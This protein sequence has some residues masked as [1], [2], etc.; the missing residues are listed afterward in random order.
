MLD[1]GF[2]VAVGVVVGFFAFVFIFL[3]F[4]REFGL[5]SVQSL[6]DVGGQGSVDDLDA[7]VSAQHQQPDRTDRPQQ[8]GA[9]LDHKRDP[10]P[11]HILAKQRIEAPHG[12]REDEQIRHDQP[13]DQRAEDHPEPVAELK[14]LLHH[15]FDRPERVGAHQARGDEQQAPELHLGLVH[16]RVQRAVARAEHIAH[17][18]LAAPAPVD[19]LRRALDVGTADGAP[20]RALALPRHRGRPRRRVP[21]LEAVPHAARKVGVE[22]RLRARHAEQAREVVLPPLHGA[23]HDLPPAARLQ[24]DEDAALHGRVPPLRL[25]AGQPRVGDD[26]GD[27]IDP[28]RGEFALP[29]F[30][31]GEDRGGG[32]LAV[33]GDP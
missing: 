16:D 12:E 17:E 18:R 1:R 32:N 30:V 7:R 33:C 2:F 5:E 22:D 31:R 6:S 11:K 13:G 9:R 8:Q 19:Q 27:E 23:L 10:R 20:P 15:R 14:I 29:G 26:H 3:V 28:G 24:P 25:A 21:Q 4:L